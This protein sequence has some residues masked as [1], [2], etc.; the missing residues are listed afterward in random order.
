MTAGIEAL[1]HRTM[2]LDAA[3]IGSASIQRAVQQRLVAREISD[4]DRYLEELNRNPEECQELIE[5]VVVPETWFFRHREAFDVLTRVA[6]EPRLPATGPLRVL[7][8]PCSTG[9]EPYT[10][11]MTLLDAGLSRAQFRIDAMD[12][13]ARSLERA[14]QALYTRN[15]FRGDGLEFRDRYFVPAGT[16]WR[17]RSEVQEAVN[18]VQGNLFDEDVAGE[19]VAD[20]D[21]VFC[22]NLL[23]YFDRAKQDHAIGVL[24]RLLSP[25]GWLFVG[26]SETAVL[27]GRGFVSGGVPRAFAYRPNGAV[28]AAEKPVSD[29]ATFTA[30]SPTVR[31]TAVRQSSPPAA[32]P[33]PLPF[34]NVVRVTKPSAPAPAPSSS[35]PDDLEAAQRLA[36]QGQLA[37]A[38]KR[39][40]AH[41]KAQGPA[42]TAYY[43]LGL[44]RDAAGGHQEAAELYRKALYLDP[45]HEQ[46]LVHLAV[47]LQDRGNDQEAER[48]FE[49]ARRLENSRPT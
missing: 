6:R 24:S 34:R 9:E 10:I 38:A 14:Q 37:E 4:V 45:R 32:R 35:L 19:L 46:A 18:F 25:K 13:S 30:A 8:L 11:A 36:D 33:Q 17:L 1:L 12:I 20:Y 16:R 7:S 23:I 31:K 28:P 40:E 29:G 3:S 22:R 27:P 48:L 5:S 21:A 2:G 49:R 44:V 39:C 15:S 26:P 47:L 41:L 43:L 42:A